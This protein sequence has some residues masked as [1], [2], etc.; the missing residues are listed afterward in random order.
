MV[1]GGAG[2]REAYLF[3]KVSS[4]LVLTDMIDNVE[5]EKLP[6]VT[7]AALRLARATEG[8]TPMHVRLALRLGGEG[9]GA[10]VQRMLVLEPECV[11]F[12]HGR[13]FE[14]RGAERLRRAFE[15]LAPPVR[16]SK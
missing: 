15:W 6:P 12:A 13:W 3:H 16:I 9:A 8:K 14:E 7:A 2:F 11:V 4:T 5:P 1:E 10:A